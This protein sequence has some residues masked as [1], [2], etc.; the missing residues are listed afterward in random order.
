MTESLGVLVGYDGSE[1]GERAL[2]WAAEEAAARRLPLTICHVWQVV[3]PGFVMMPVDA[4]E[5]SATELVEAAADKARSTHPG[6][7]VTT[8]TISGS[9]AFNLVDQARDAALTVV[10]SV[11]MGAFRRAL[12]GTV[13]SQV[14][15]HGSGVITVVRGE[16][17][18]AGPV[19]VGLDGSPL[20]AAVLRAAL[21]EAKARTAR[22]V[23]LCVYPE[24]AEVKDA[25]FVEEDRLRDIAR[26][27]FEAAVRAGAEDFP[28]VEV[29]PRFV[30]GDP[31]TELIT[32]S[33]GARVL[34]VGARRGGSL[35][36][37]LL[38]SSSE[39]AVHHALS[40]VTVVH[41][42]EA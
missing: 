41:P 10:G 4:L 37:R 7:T 2:A 14:A 31:V 33:E 32:A 27:R 19:V 17:N 34:V 24:S 39:G 11:G 29:Q 28:G 8:R 5:K 6:L 23:A 16:D 13:G 9:P 3:Y 20:S 36:K 40:P 18:P 35:R 42:P 22:V 1:G 26:E 38:G 21:E 25:P 15:A 30:D 12:I